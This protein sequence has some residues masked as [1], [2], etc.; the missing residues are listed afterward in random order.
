MVGGIKPTK[1]LVLGG[2]AYLSQIVVALLLTMPRRWR[3]DRAR[4]ALAQQNGMTAILLALLLEPN[5]PG[6]IGIVAPAVVVVNVLHALCNGLWVRLH[7]TVPAT[8]P[9]ISQHGPGVARHH[10][11]RLVS[12]P[13]PTENAVGHAE[14]SS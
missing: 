13:S 9:P 11:F 3:G 12:S 2:A 4:L 7:H 5:F 6:P 1:A 14:H 10:R 8:T